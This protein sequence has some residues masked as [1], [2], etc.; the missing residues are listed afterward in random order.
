MD[1]ALHTAQPI[2]EQLKDIPQLHTQAMRREAFHMF[3][4]VTPLTKK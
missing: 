3:G 1:D 4:L 2:I